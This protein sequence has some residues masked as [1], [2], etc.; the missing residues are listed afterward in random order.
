MEDVKIIA[1]MEN[2]VY[3]QKRNVMLAILLALLV[4]ALVLKIV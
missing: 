4:L 2:L 1:L 3:Y